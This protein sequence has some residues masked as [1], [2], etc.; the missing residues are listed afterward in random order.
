LAQT[1]DHAALAKA[2][3]MAKH[4]ASRSEIWDTTGWFKGEDGKW[5]FEIP[6]AAAEFRYPQQTEMKNWRLG[7][8]VDHSALFDAYPNLKKSKVSTDPASDGASYQPMGGKIELGTKSGAPDMG[9]ALH[10]IQH[11]IQSREGF[12]GGTNAMAEHG[13]RIPTAKSVRKSLDDYYNNPGEIEARNVDR[14]FITQNYEKPPWETADK[15]S[16]F[17][18]DMPAT[19][20]DRPTL[21]DVGSFAKDNW[22]L[23]S[24]LGLMQ[25]PAAYDLAKWLASGKDKKPTTKKDGGSVGLLRARRIKRRARHG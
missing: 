25:A 9:S 2:E 13:F 23:L 12:A 10:E 15:P 20:S 3:Q 8:A 24:S 6:D 17:Y 18:S 21:A 4:G 5:R 7:D 11:A 19:S 16:T 14:R 1:A 22:K